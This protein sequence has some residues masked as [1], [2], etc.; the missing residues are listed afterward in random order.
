MSDGPPPEGAAGASARPRRG[1]QG[2]LLRLL[3]R[4][5]SAALWPEFDQL[6][7]DLATALAAAVH[8]EA[9]TR[10]DLQHHLEARLDQS[11]AALADLRQ[12]YL[13][14]RGEF[15]DVRD[16]RIAELAAQRAMRSAR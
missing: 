16:R 11:A 14:T 10:A 15:E 6:E 13:V 12:A 7:G 3:R 2:W 4:V 1:T 8:R 5:A 9:A